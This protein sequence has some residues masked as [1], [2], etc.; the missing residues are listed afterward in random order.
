M[1]LGFLGVGSA[2]NHQQIF[3]RIAPKYFILAGM[4]IVGGFVSTVVLIVKNVIP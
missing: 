3:Q 1:V 2:K 4:M